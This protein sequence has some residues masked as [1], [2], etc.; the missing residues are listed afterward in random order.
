ML[1]VQSDLTGSKESFYCI[2]KFENDLFDIKVT[3]LG[4]HA[5]T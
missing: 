3:T 4:I 2:G 1:I 5:H